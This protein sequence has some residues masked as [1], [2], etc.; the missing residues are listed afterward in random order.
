[1][2]PETLKRW[3]ARLSLTQ[4]G[5]SEALGV[6]VGTYRGWESA[7]ERRQARPAHSRLVGLA[8]AAVSAD[9]KPVK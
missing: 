8:C 5:A 1:M 7:D 6:P 2:T 9:L 3:R 4:E